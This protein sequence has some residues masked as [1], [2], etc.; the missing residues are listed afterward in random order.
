MEI[1]ASRELMVLT[2]LQVPRSAIR[3]AW[4]FLRTNPVFAYG[5]SLVEPSRRKSRTSYGGKQPDESRLNVGFWMSKVP[6]SITEILI[7]D[8]VRG[9]PRTWKL[10][11]RSR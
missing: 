1:M 6:L 4:P 10:D 5:L 8:P 2:S 7:L 11:H 9:F 3:D